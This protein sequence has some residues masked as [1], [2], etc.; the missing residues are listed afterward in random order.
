VQFLPPDSPLAQEAL[1]SAIDT[2]VAGVKTRV[3]TAEHLVALA[4][5]LGRAKDFA[6]ILQFIEAGVLDTDKLNQILERHGLLE[7]WRQFSDRF[8]TNK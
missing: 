8:L 5:R 2:T 6:R 1:D 7:K 3:M 4:L